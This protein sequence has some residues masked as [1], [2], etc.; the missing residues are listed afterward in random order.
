M[1]YLFDDLFLAGVNH[2]IY[3]GTC[4]SPDEAPWPGWLFYASTEMNPRNSI[5]RDVPALNA[6]AARCQSIL[7]SGQPDNDILLCWP[8]HD[9]WHNAKGMAPGF[10]VHARDWLDGQAIGQL[11]RRL[12][13]RGYTFDYV[14]DRQLASAKAEEKGI[15][16]PGGLYRAVVVPAC[17]HFPVGSLEKLLTLAESGTTVVFEQQLPADVPGWA[18]LERRRDAL[19]RRLATLNFSGAAAGPIKEARLGRGRVLVGEAEAALVAVKVRREA[20]T[21][22]EGLC[23]FRR[24]F[25]GGRHRFIA[26]RGDKPFDG[27][28]PLATVAKSVGVMD[29]MTGRTGVGVVRKG[30]GGTTETYVQLQPG[31]S[32]ILKAF[33][34]QT[35]TGN[36]WTW[37]QNA[38]RPAEVQGTW[39]VKFIQGGPQLPP[40]SQTAKLASWTELGGEE[41]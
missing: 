38:G 1:K 8:I 37:W 25:E 32:I 16:T 33:S 31:E 30:K 2:V 18:E 24:S 29:P 15:V 21:D 20:M 34:A 11:G 13:K 5:W 41:A 4:Y 14:S 35:V 23:C 10:T 19:K 7:Q 22:H 26:N 27:W 39:Q 28:L 12:W 3:H 17:E 36:V 9:R 6:Y 40:P